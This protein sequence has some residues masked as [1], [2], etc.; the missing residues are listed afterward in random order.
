MQADGASQNNPD[1]KAS[2]AITYLNMTGVMSVHLLTGFLLSKSAEAFRKF[3]DLILGGRP[4]PSLTELVLNYCT[5]PLPM[6]AGLILGLT[7]AGLLWYLEKQ[8]KGGIVQLVLL[9]VLIENFF[10]MGV[11]L[12]SVTLPAVGMTSTLSP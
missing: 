2:S 12:L 4:L 7:F 6:I 3:Y 10:F 9:A 5:S 1:M 8:G 11:Y